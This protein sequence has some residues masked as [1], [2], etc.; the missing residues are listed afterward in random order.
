MAIATVGT[1][2]LAG[3]LAFTILVD[4]AISRIDGLQLERERP[5]QVLPEAR[6][7]SYHVVIDVDVGSNGGASEPSG[8][9][10]GVEVDA[11]VNYVVG[12]GW[13]SELRL[14]CSN[15]EWCKAGVLPFE[16]SLS[17][18]LLTIHVPV[19][20]ANIAQNLSIAWKAFVI[21]E[22]GSAVMVDVVPERG[23]V[24]MDVAPVLKPAEACL[25]R[26]GENGII[27]ISAT[28]DRT[29]SETSVLTSVSEQQVQVRFAALIILF[30]ALS[31]SIVLLRTQPPSGN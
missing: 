25:R 7:I 16:V 6:R 14:R 29:S 20:P 12:V 17:P 5:P 4:G 30:L 31:A 2:K 24:I 9:W 13:G 26:V 10:E 3:S 18:G 11:S 21:Q 23:R 15:G 1:Y 28:S 27:A 22:T 8:L 19:E